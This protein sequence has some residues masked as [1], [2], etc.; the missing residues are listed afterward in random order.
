MIPKKR[1]SAAGIAFVRRLRMGAALAA[2]VA[3]MLLLTPRA[4][5]PIEAAAKFKPAEFKYVGGTENLPADCQG[6]LEI[7]SNRLVF[8][9]PEGSVEIPYD[10]IVVMEYRSDVSRNLRRMNL[11][12]TSAPWSLR[13]KTNR[14][15]TVV[16]NRRG[17]KQ[18]LVLDV[19]PEAMRPYFAEIDLKSGLRVQVENHEKYDY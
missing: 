4:A 12:W 1:S 19:S 13:H 18:A 7:T 6:K 9:C 3:S 16:Y 17:R 10:S 2:G 15:F 14:Y 11:N 5:L 8:S